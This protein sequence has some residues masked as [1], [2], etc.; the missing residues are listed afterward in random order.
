MVTGR[1]CTNAG[2][3][4]AAS[5]TAEN[6]N[7]DLRMRRVDGTS[8]ADGKRTDQGKGNGLTPIQCCMKMQIMA[9]SDVGYSL[10][11]NT[12]ALWYHTRQIAMF[13]GFRQKRRCTCP[14]I[15][16]NILWQIELNP[17]VTNQ[18]R[19]HNLQ[20]NVHDQTYIYTM[21]CICHCVK[22]AAHYNKLFHE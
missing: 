6:K 3:L 21:H 8:L 15:S 13:P 16:I 4:V 20:C 12:A 18:T 19:L 2:P 7:G 1:P 9:T 17:T 11:L 5:S 22:N 10:H 14:I